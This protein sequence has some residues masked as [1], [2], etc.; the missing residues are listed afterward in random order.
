ML[1]TS[2]AFVTELHS[3]LAAGSTQL[4]KNLETCLGPLPILSSKCQTGLGE[5]QVG[6]ANGEHRHDRSRQLLG[7]WIE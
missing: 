7:A 4:M 3:L 6:S 2:E 5:C 1:R